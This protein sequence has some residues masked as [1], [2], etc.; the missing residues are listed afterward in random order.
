MN[1]I[2]ATGIQH[3]G[4]PSNNIEETVSFFESLGFSKIYS[5]VNHTEK[6]C[7]L[8]LK[9]LIIETYENN[10][11]Q[12][13]SGAIDHIAIDVTDI[14]DTYKYVTTL[15]YKAIEKDIQFLPFWENGVKYFTITGPDMEKIEFSQK[16]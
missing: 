10:Q 3:I 6:V 9:N 14:E 12:M 5:T 16:L 1:S 2:G 11:A 13:I 15:G 8:V 4:I 7:F